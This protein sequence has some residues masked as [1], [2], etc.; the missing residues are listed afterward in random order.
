[1][2]L[3]KIKYLFAFGIMLTGGSL[4]AQKTITGK[5]TAAKDGDVIPGAIVIE[6]GTTNG[7]VANLEGAYSINVSDTAKSLIFQMSGMKTDTVS[8]DG[9][10]TIDDVMIDNV[11]NLN[12]VIVTAL[13]VSKEKK[14]LGYSVSEVSG[15]E[16][17]NAGETNVIESLSSKAA[18]VTVTSTGGSPGASSKITI[19]GNS[20]FTGNNQPLIIVDGVP[21]DN[22]TTAS[23]AGD[24]PFNPTLNGVSNSNR[25]LDINPDDI[26]SVTILKGPAAA[27]LYGA[28]A[29]S[30]AIIYT[31]KKG[32]YGKD[33]GMGVTF[34]SNVEFEMVNKLPETQKTYA[35]GLWNDPTYF[36]DSASYITSDPGPDNAYNTADDVDFGTSSS[37]GPKI[38]SLPGITYHDNAKAFFKT[39]I[40]TNN[41]IAI[42]G[43]NE[44][45][46]YRFSYGNTSQKGIIPNSTL[47]RNTFLISGEHKVSE[48]FK[49]GTVLNYV[50]TRGQSPQNGSNLSGIMLGLL[51]MPGSFDINPYQY[52]SNGYNR[53][54]FGLY[55]NP[56]F[57]AY[58]NP[59]TSTV[60]RVYGNTYFMY[61]PCKSFQITY[62]LGSDFYNDNRSQIYAVSSNGD[63]NT[64]GLGQMNLESINS[65]QIYSDLVGT[66]MHDFGENWHS[67]ISLGNN[68]WSKSL[69]EQFSRGR[70]FGIP[71]FY[72][73]SNAAE[74][75][76]SQYSEAIRTVAGFVDGTIDYKSA[77]FLNVT[78][79]NEWS[80]TFNSKA[81]GGKDGFL[82]PSVSISTVISELVE[83]PKWF[84]FAKVRANYAEAGVS[85]EPYRNR[86]YYGQSTFTDGF[87]NGN[88]FPYL[89]QV[90]YGISSILGN[91]DLKPE[92]VKGSEVGADLRFFGS[93]LNFDFTYYHQKTVDILVQ[94]PVA[95]SSGFSNIY[96]N[97]G[98]MLNSG[99]E[100]EAGGV[101]V[102]T[103]NFKWDITF[104]WSANK[105][106]VL[107]LAPGVTE[108]S[109]EEGFE[110][111]GAYAI[112][113]QPYGV[114][115]GSSWQRNADGKLIIN[116]ATGL[117]YLSPTSVAL[118]NPAPKWQSGIRNTL[119]YKNLSFTFLWDIR[120]GGKIWNGT[121]M[122]IDRLGRGVDTEN[123][124]QNYT[125][126]GVLATGVNADGTA[127]A[128]DQ[129]NNVSIDA[130]T[131]FQKYQGDLGGATEMGIQ[132][133]GWV[134]LRDVSVSY[135][136]Q[137][138]NQKYIQHIDF[139]ASGRNMLLFTKY[140][141]V[142]PETSLTGAGS[143]ISG[144]DYFNNPGTKSFMFGVRVAF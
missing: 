21:V 62:R 57:T 89:G 13:G 79:R 29:G 71:G 135:R 93:R 51:R 103:T 40:T 112:V 124:D 60:N 129:A 116:P 115:Y 9:R 77:I 95:P 22:S 97:S 76:A 136:Y 44:R 83:L 80:S 17:A 48:K 5:I 2:H 25:A 91:P 70:T 140:T 50:N 134:R 34:S 42:T 118:G 53:T 43:G 8:I 6:P 4:L 49:V 85:P 36:S 61:T 69:N 94:R 38:S 35:Q 32:A 74:L 64:T 54:Y 131:Y 45:T 96:Q 20:T 132:D 90:G 144:F 30:G 81:D 24:N 58:R 138:K 65:M 47:N 11:N 16:V 68:I 126:D 39:G 110:S 121:K 37:W 82:Y 56:L 98:E 92:R 101:P 41:S 113:G 75:Y 106:K 86:T 105:S 109:L 12:E 19:R 67:S 141:G 99:F 125:I 108:I 100:V 55:D 18:G 133:A 15:Q 142:D 119:T 78:A 14:A 143:N 139:T 31:T 111:I 122:R 59:Y 33:K 123:R 84:S 107:K 27:A 102:K 46:L 137:F 73:L 104:N 114:L 117:P 3:T 28:R 1:M 7:T 10:S 23:G 128:G 127:I 120:N 63:D 88:S 52:E 66:Y 87:T 130:K 72:S 26:E